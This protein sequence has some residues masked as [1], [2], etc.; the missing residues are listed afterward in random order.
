M[1]L[2]REHLFVFLTR[3][4]T[5]AAAYFGLPAERTVTLSRAVAI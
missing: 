4:A 2:W 1:A 3:N 5:P